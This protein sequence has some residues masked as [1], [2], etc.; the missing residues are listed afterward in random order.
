MKNFLYIIGFALIPTGILLG[1]SVNKWLGI[2]TII[3]GVS[4][5]IF[6]IFRKEKH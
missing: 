4:I 1:N 6:S 3:V 2:A 5:S